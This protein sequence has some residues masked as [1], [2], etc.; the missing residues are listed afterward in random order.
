MTAP[1]SPVEVTRSRG[2]VAVTPTGSNRRKPEPYDVV[3]VCP[4]VVIDGHKYES[5]RL[6]IIA[7]SLD[8]TEIDATEWTGGPPIHL[9]AAEFRL[10]SPPRGQR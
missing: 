6:T 8:G 5:V 1:E 3:A 7:V 9:G 10:V 4:G 2:S